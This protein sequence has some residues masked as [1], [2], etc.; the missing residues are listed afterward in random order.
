MNEYIFVAIWVGK[1]KAAAKYPGLTDL[2]TLTS[3]PRQRLERKILGKRALKRIA[4][5]VDK[6]A[7]KKFDDKFGNNFNYALN[8][9]DH[10][11]SVD[12]SEVQQWA[13]AE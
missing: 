6:K 4:E 3:N 8:N 1:K 9:W 13:C 5:E 11:E 7:A 2:S 12:V 10:T